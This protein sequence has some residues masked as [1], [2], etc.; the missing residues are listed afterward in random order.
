MLCSLRINGH[1]VDLEC[2]CTKG[3]AGSYYDP[4]E[5]PEIEIL[6][7]WVVRGKRSREIVGVDFEDFADKYYTEI[8]DAI[9]DAEWED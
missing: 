2:T 3:Y 1:K 5:P 9:Y 8:L 4:P 6:R 7:L